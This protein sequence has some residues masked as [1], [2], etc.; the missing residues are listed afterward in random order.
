MAETGFRQAR[1]SVTSFGALFSRTPKPN[2]A[3]GTHRYDGAPLPFRKVD[4]CSRFLTRL[5][6]SEIDWI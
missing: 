1:L 5:L 6:S 4:V 3:V 2:F